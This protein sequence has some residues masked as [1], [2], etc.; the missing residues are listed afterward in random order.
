MSSITTIPNTSC[1]HTFNTITT[2]AQRTGIDWGYNQS[3]TN[4][5]ENTFDWRDWIMELKDVPDVTSITILPE[6][7]QEFILFYQKEYKFAD[8]K[9]IYLKT[10]T[11]INIESY[12]YVM[13]YRNEKTNIKVTFVLSSFDWEHMNT[14]EREFTK[15]TEIANRYEE[16]YITEVLKMNR[17]KYEELMRWANRNGASVRVEADYHSE[18]EIKIEAPI[19][20]FNDVVFERYKT[21]D[22][23]QKSSYE[24][25]RKDYLAAGY[26]VKVETY[27]GRVV[28][29]TFSDGTFTKSVC[30]END[31]FDLDVGITICLM[32]RMLGKDGHKKYNNAMRYIHNLIEENN[33]KAEEEKAKKAKIKE[34]NRKKNERRAEG[35]KKAIRQQIDIQKTAILEAMSENRGREAKI[36]NIC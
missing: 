22:S 3:V 19:H 14:K 5:I 18:A 21:K 8:L 31:K 20:S 10:Q 30:S 7:I 28:K 4:I 29:V 23:V 24:P 17:E 33:K 25:N 16:C 32:K 11:N 34:E 9:D 2:T 6:Y 1:S 27:N 15:M 35:R 26:V 36:P 13:T 12:L